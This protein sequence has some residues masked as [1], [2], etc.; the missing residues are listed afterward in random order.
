MKAFAIHKAADLARIAPYRGIAERFLFDA[1]PPPGSA[2]PGGNGVRFDWTILAGLD[3][4][5][6]YML[7]GGLDAANI[8]DA[9]RLA[10]PPGIDI[11]SGVESEP[12]VKDTALIEAFFKAV[13]A[14]RDDRAA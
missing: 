6:D 10:N 14:A 13:A 7:S 2:L 4:G 9:L 12:G 3:A 5:V 11:S 8:A 1:K